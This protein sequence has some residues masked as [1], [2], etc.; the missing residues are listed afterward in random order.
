MFHTVNRQFSTLHKAN[1]R[2][3]ITLFPPLFKWYKYPFFRQATPKVLIFSDFYIYF[4][5]FPKYWLSLSVT[6]RS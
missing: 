1:N 3:K 2:C 4:T 6:N 5:T